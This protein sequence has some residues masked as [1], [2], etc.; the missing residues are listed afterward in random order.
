MSLQETIERE[1]AKWRSLHVEYMVLMGSLLQH[2]LRLFHL[3]AEMANCQF[4][5]QEMRQVEALPELKVLQA[6]QAPEQNPS[7]PA[8]VTTLSPSANAPSGPPVS[9]PK[10]EDAKVPS[11]S[12]KPVS[13]SRLRWTQ[14]S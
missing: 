11:I 10:A 6:P 7:S 1:A 9:D 5:I 3:E 4:W 14:G 13:G 2:R 12:V 8:G